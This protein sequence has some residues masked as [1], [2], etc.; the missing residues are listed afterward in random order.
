VSQLS[1][2]RS[3]REIA[4]SALTAGVAVVCVRHLLVADGIEP[5]PRLALSI[6]AGAAF[7]VSSLALIAPAVARRLLGMVRGLAPAMRPQR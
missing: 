5:E 3:L 4:L 1:V 6:V 2:L 7:Y